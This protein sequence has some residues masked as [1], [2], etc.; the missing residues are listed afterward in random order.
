MWLRQ[1]AD[2]GEK[3]VWLAPMKHSDSV[4]LGMNVIKLGIL[5]ILLH[6]KTRKRSA[7]IAFH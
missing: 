1:V 4:K 6:E 5:V 7:N 2:E 3:E